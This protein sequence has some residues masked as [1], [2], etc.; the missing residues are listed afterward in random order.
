MCF[1][2]LKSG[3]NH[4]CTAGKA[5]RGLRYAELFTTGFLSVPFLVW[6]A[7]LPH[8]SAEFQKNLSSGCFSLA[9]VCS[10]GLRTEL[11]QHTVLI[12]LSALTRTCRPDFENLV[13]RCS[14]KICTSFCT[15]HGAINR[16]LYLHMRAK[17]AI[18]RLIPNL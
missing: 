6:G 12:W 3:L 17:K 16:I 10:F 4:C 14:C 1:L 2:H 13:R 7:K 11:C 15:V 5:G 8:F 9:L 18:A